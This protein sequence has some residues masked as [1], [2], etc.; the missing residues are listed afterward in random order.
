LDLRQVML[1][2]EVVIL[3]LVV[4]VWGCGLRFVD[5]HGEE[6]IEQTCVPAVRNI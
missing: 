2:T 6:T 4:G 3:K 1:K 5:A